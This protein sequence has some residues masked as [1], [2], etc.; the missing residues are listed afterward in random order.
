MATKRK[1]LST[2]KNHLTRTLLMSLL[3]VV[4]LPSSLITVTA[5][6][7]APPSPSR[8]IIW[9]T[10]LTKT[11]A[12]DMVNR[13]KALIGMLSI[14]VGGVV[15]TFFPALPARADVSS[16]DMPDGAAQ[17]NRIIR[18]KRDLKVCLYDVL[19]LFFES[20]AESFY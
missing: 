3:V 1:S 17:F 6:G 9:T 10:P 20:S 16:G 7:L 14:V 13:K 19:L 15:P 11:T 12:L 18:L 8:N 4:V 5:F 2:C